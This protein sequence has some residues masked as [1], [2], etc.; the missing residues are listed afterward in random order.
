MTPWRELFY[1]KLKGLKLEGE[2]LDMGGAVDADYHNLFQKKDGTHI[3]V[4]GFDKNYGYDIQADLEK[5][6]TL[7][8]NQYDT[9]LCFNLLE[10]IFNYE[11]VLQE[12]YR[13]LKI[14][15]QF[16]LAVPFL[17]NLHPCPADYWRFSGDCLRKN[18]EKTGYRNIEVIEIYTGL[19]ETLF[20]IAYNF[21]GFN[22][23][24]FV[25]K[26]IA[27]FLDLLLGLI[28]GIKYKNLIKNYPL[29]YLVKAYK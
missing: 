27:I 20:Q 11:N 25:F 12:S 7:N 29:G 28:G 13:V 15:G 9:V 8:N 24:R 16:L 4:L 2:V 10:H 17:F 14:N 26:K 18:L 6:T 23:L 5:A 21:Y 1:K 3:Y 22:F 19:F